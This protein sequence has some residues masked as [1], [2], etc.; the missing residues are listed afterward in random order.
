MKN[1]CDLDSKIE[2]HVEKHGDEAQKE[3]LGI[4]RKIKEGLQITEEELDAHTKHTLKLLLFPFLRN[5]DEINSDGLEGTIIAA[6]LA[7]ADVCQ[8]RAGI[9]YPEL[10]GKALVMR[11]HHNKK[12]ILN[13]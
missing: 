3:L 8:E 5:S 10:F 7:M 9:P 11:S 13:G 2:D 1:Q 12:D 4:A 6:I